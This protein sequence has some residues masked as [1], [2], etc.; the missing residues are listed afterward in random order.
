MTAFAGHCWPQ[1]TGWDHGF[2]RSWGAQLRGFLRDRSNLLDAR[3]ELFGQFHRIELTTEGD[4][5]VAPDFMHGAPLYVTEGD[6]LT[7]ISNR[8]GL[9]AMAVNPDG[10]EPERSL[11]GAGWLLCMGSMLDEESGYWD[12]QHIPFGS[13]VRIAPRSGASIVE[14]QHSPLAPLTESSYE[15]ALDRA[16]HELRTTMRVIA[17]LP[18]ADLELALSGGKDSRL[19][20]AIILNEGLRDRFRFMTIG[21]AEK[22]DPIA[23]RRIA[24]TFDLDWS[25]I[26]RSDRSP[27]DAL[28]EV[29]AHT[30]LVEGLTSAWDA[31]GPTAFGY[32]ATVSGFAG[33]YLRWGPVALKGTTAKSQA[34]LLATLRRGIGLDPLGILRPDVR[35]YYL[36]ALDRWAIQHLERGESVKRV[37]AFYMQE[38]RVRDRAGPT[39]AWNARWR[40]SPF[41]TRVI[42]Q[43]NHSL[44]EPAR[45]D[46]RFQID[47]MRRHNIALSKLPFAASTWGEASIAHLP[48]AED[49]RRVQAAVTTSA[50]ARNWRL[51]RYAGYRPML[52]TYL[53]DRENPI[54]ELV[55]FERLAER[56]ASG[57]AHPGRTRML[58]GALT[59]AIWMGHHELDA[60]I[61]P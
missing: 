55:S 18:I 61:T 29:R 57:D 39:Q 9:A 49:Y 5:F 37:A 41:P 19:L 16:D 28:H 54:H 12:A 6:E 45:P 21:P 7:A 17:E 44:P 13:H 1:E 51:M 32:G 31:V 43:A 23:A 47:L 36:Q 20:T 26:D 60:R 25:L 11:M 24:T 4:G 2:G 3:D 35:E 48:D 22:A 52:E 27:G 58:W 34:E 10:V 50:D 8:A 30:G 40:L 56:I 15:E 46:H 38:T 14:A 53:L 42:V 33:E 59:A